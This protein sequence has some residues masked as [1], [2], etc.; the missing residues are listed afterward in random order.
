M[1]RAATEINV[2]R[3][4]P[5]NIDVSWKIR[6]T[7][8][9]FWQILSLF[10]WNKTGDDDAVLEPAC[11]ALAKKAPDEIIH[12][13]EILAEKLYAIDTRRHC[14]ACYAGELD[15][16]NGD[17]YISADDFLYQRC[18]VVA[19]GREFYYDVRDNPGAFPQG[20]EFEALL[21]LGSNAFERATGNEFEHC[22]AVSYESFQNHDGWE[23][24]EETNPGK[25]TGDGMPPGN[26]RPT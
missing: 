17:D 26:R 11:S 22:T 5:V 7:E 3:R 6:M 14:K 16:D 1:G 12:F 10:D 13:E 19:N 15:P 23:A 25:F 2:V 21:S 8:L 24:T 4:D 20:M 9:E 18:V